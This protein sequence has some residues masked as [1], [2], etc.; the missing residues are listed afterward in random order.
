MEDGKTNKRAGTFYEETQKIR[1][2]G[3]QDS[4]QWIQNGEITF[5]EE[6]LLIATQDQGLTTNW[7]LKCVVLEKMTSADYATLLLK[8]PVIWS[9][10]ARLCMLM[11]QYCSMSQ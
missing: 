7:F 5:D 6:R 9:L 2:S 1:H 10:V 4:F 11:D 8:T 3:T